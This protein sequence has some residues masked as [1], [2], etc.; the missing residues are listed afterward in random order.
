MTPQ[1][2]DLSRSQHPFRSAVLRG[3]GVVLPP[4]LTI[5]IFLWVWRTVQYYGL[6]PVQR[7]A[8][9][10]IVGW[11]GD[12]RRDLPGEHSVGE[13]VGY[14]G[15]E[16]VRLSDRSYVPLEVRDYVQ[17]QQ[18]APLPQTGG[19]MYRRYV[20]L[21]YLAPWVVV[22]VFLCLFL[23]LLYL[24][25]KFMA[26]GIG[27]VMVN[28]LEGLIRRLPLIRN[29]YSSVKQV[30]DFMFNESDIE[31]TRVV[32]IEYPRKGIWSIGL[33]TG[34]SLADI[35]TAAHEPVLAVLVPASP[36]PVT[37]FTVT[38]PKRE[39]VD[40]NITIDQALQ[41]IISCGVVV[42]PQQQQPETITLMVD[43]DRKPAV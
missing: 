8:R 10:V 13:I 43:R 30:T 29:V 17:D 6:E 28:L 40:L 25:G 22:P 12:I 20:E 32:A 42:P 39:A 15:R 14:E 34:E 26:A 38:V 33:V 11:V 16:Y 9:E 31:Y 41:F 36:M 7:G 35:R 19:G 2:D 18:G 37:G 4:L 1:A 24:L 3:L 5:V 27:R 23:L 21:K